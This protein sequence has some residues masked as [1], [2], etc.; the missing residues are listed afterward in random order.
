MFIDISHFA[1]S[2]LR[3]EQHKEGEPEQRV[4]VPLPGA[5]HRARAAGRVLCPV[6]EHVPDHGAGE[7][8]H[9][10]GPSP[11]HPHVLLCHHL[12]L[13]DVSISIVTLP[14]MLMNMQA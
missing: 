1:T 13:T 12:A 10:A 9:Q 6:P 7:P 14:K 5:S 11:P 2:Q 4:R 8:A 3:Q